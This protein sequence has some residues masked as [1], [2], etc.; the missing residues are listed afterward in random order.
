MEWDIYI[1]RIRGVVRV[2]GLWILGGVFATLLVLTILLSWL[3]PRFS[4]LLE[5]LLVG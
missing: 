1:S 4:K 3:D 5:R 2:D